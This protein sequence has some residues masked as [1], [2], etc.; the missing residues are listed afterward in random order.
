M[1]KDETYIPAEKSTK[2]WS[3]SLSASVTDA[4][5]FLR[6]DDDPNNRGDKEFQ[7]Q[8]SDSGQIVSLV[9][10]NVHGN[11][12]LQSV[13]SKAWIDGKTTRERG[14]V[15][16]V[17]NSKDD[18]HTRSILRPGKEITTK[19]RD[20]GKIWIQYIGLYE[21]TPVDN[22]LISFRQHPSTTQR[23]NTL[24]THDRNRNL[25]P[26]NYRWAK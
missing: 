1:K 12:L 25:R 16:L 26:T 5:V 10:L 7:R 4:A 24:S 2:A 8:Q 17:W 18:Q 13:A 6:R 3:M 22:N 19:T 21:E 14:R 15:R 20:H 11:R 23:R 9:V